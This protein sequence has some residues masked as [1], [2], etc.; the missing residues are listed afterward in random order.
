MSRRI[1]LA[2]L[3]ALALPLR[4]EDEEIDLSPPITVAESWL[5]LLDAGR[6]GTA[7]EQ[8]A[9]MFQEAM[10]RHRWETTLPGARDPLG[11]TLNRKMRQANLHS[12]L[13]NAPP[14]PYVVMQFDTRFEQRPLTTEIVTIQ[15]VG[16]RWMVS[17][18]VI[19]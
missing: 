18:Y 11:G 1:L 7:W 13:P 10:S 2:M 4:A 3:L 17:G 15:R 6:Y 14:G 9:P 19:R 16:E 5:S 12:S 8:A